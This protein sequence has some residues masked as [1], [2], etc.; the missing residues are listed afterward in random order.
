[1]T[2]GVLLFGLGEPL[3]PK[4]ESFAHVPTQGLKLFQGLLDKVKLLLRQG[5]HLTARYTTTVPHGEN[6][7]QL[8]QGKADG[9]RRAQGPRLGGAD[10]PVQ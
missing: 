7:R 3:V 5:A 9:D 10:L 2:Q 1:M 8:R 4:T 6:P